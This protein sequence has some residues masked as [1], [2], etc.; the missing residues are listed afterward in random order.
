MIYPFLYCIH[1][2]DPCILSTQMELD[3][4]VRLYELNKDSELTIHGKL[5]TPNLFAF[6]LN[7]IVRLN[8]TQILSF[9]LHYQSNIV[10]L[11]TLLA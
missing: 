2:G 7:I 6:H 8:G 3:E 5:S 11:L 1:L 10:K 4:A 9:S